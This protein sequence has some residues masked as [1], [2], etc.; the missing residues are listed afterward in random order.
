MLRV[1]IGEIDVMF[2]QKTVTIQ[3][4]YHHWSFDRK[5]MPR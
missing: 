5:V 1:I 4:K 2:Q 3:L